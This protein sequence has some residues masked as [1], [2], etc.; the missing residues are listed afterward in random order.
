[1][2][3]ELR[4]IP[5]TRL[6]GKRAG[7]VDAYLGA[8]CGNATQAARMCGFL[9][10][11]A[12]GYRM[13][14]DPVVREEIDRR[15]GEEGITREEVLWRLSA[16]ARGVQAAYMRVLHTEATGD[17]G[18]L[19]VDYNLLLRDGH[20]H[21]IRRIVDTECGQSVE[22]VDPLKALTL[23]ARL[24]GMT[25]QAQDVSDR[26]EMTIGEALDRKLDSIAAAIGAE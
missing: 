25:Q 10:P 2:D 18:R 6:R 19:V 20:G 7:F 26:E 14:R 24:L 3:D 4:L 17:S 5:P 11:R 12:A 16:L 21:C 23:C 15:L 9:A 13:L 8:A 22:F 1:M